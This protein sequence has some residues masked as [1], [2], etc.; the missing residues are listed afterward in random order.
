MSRG[1][2]GAGGPRARSLHRSSPLVEA[3]TANGAAYST[4]VLNLQT[5]DATFPGLVPASGAAGNVLLSGISW[6]KVDLSTHITGNLSTSRLN[7]GTGASASTF[8]RGDGTWATPPAGITSLGGLSTA[9]QTFAVGTSGT[10]FNISS[11]GSTH[12]F[13]IPDASATA[14][15]AVNTGTQTFAGVKEFTGSI[16]LTGAGSLLLRFNRTGFSGVYGFEQ[17][18]NTLGLFDYTNTKYRI[19]INSDNV[20]LN[21]SGGNVGIGT[22]SPNAPL[23]FGNVTGNRKIVLFESANDDHQF[24]GLGFNSLAMRY[25]VGGTSANHVWYAGTS[26]TTSNELMVLTG[27]GMLGIGGIT[28]TGKGRLTINGN[29][30]NPELK[31]EFGGSNLFATIEGPTNRELRVK[32]ID[33]EGGDAFTIWS[34]NGGTSAERF[35]FAPSGVGTATDWVATS[36]R[37]LKYNIVDAESQLTKVKV[38]ASLVRN[39]DRTDTKENETGFIAQEL[40]EVAPE[41]VTKPDNDS[42]MWAVNYSKMVVPLYKAIEELTAKVERLE[43]NEQ[44]KPIIRRAARRAKYKTDN[45]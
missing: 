23:Q 1:G 13:N 10:T 33:N 29:G 37:R 12:T 18:T 15:G 5:A 2:L 20:L 9:T 17:S 45:Q 14:R 30:T 27:T 34:N 26:S 3:K 44:Q 40:F 36:D 4:G 19:R 39:Y 31:L 43:K 28:P 42:T 38:I 32:L 8:W 22:T 16:D 21:E 24:Y 11:S 7:S 6:G 41:Y 25:Q 35:R